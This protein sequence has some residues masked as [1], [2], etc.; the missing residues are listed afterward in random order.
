MVIAPETRRGTVHQDINHIGE[1]QFLFR[2]DPRFNEKLDD[3]FVYDGDVEEC[4]R[5]S[6]DELALIN[7]ILDAEPK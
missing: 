4:E 1:P 7:K 3:F 2:L 6:D 5:P